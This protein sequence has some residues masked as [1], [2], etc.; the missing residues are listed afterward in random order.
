MDGAGIMWLFVSLFALMGVFFL[1]GRGAGLI[2]MP[3][4]RR[5]E[6]DEKVLCRFVGRYLLF[7]AVC[8][9]LIILSEHVANDY[10]GVIAFVMAL[11]SSAWVVIRLLM[12]R[13]GKNG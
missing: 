6:W 13:R 1:S 10:V 9:M 11:G 2:N 7:L 4:A 5:D 3:R 12:P 8:F